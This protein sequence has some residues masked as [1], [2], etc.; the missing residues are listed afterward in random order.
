LLLVDAIGAAGRAPLN[1]LPIMQYYIFRQKT[2]RVK[3]GAAAVD[4]VPDNIDCLEWIDGNNM[5]L[6]IEK[7]PLLLDL[8]L[9]S[10]SF[11]GAIIDGL[12]TLYHRVVLEAI[13][14]FGVDNIQYFPVTLRD[15][16]S[17]KLEENQYL[18]VNIIGLLDCVDME[19]SKVSWWKTGRGFDFESMVL[20]EGRTQGL[21]IFRLKDDPTK[22]IITQ[23][24]KNHLES[25]KLMIGVNV[26]RTEDYSDW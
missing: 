20:D 18:L 4:S 6:A 10:G 9:E 15:Q 17:G 3:G 13:L 16:K 1:H 8:S 26:I 21:P 24:L 12:V 22:V 11:R 5:P 25:K 7:A 23:G 2:L 14:D 19:R